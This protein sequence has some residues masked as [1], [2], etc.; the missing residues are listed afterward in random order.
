MEEQVNKFDRPEL[1]IEG[2]SAGY[3]RRTVLCDLSLSVMRGELLAVIGANGAGKSTLLKAIMGFADVTAGVISCSGRDITRIPP[4]RRVQL[5]LS[6]LMQ[7]AVVFQSLTVHENLSVAAAALP[8]QSRSAAVEQV[9]TDSPQINSLLRTR[10]GLLSGGQ[11]QALAIGMMMVRRPRVLLLDEP[12]AG[13]APR[14]ATETLKRL[15]EIGQATGVTVI[16]VEQRVR[17][18]LEIAT[19]AI[20]LNNGGVYAETRHPSDWLD[21]ERIE[22]H[23]FGPGLPG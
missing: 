19:R 6:C 14:V 2:L 7:G 4:H 12:S 18:V 21:L 10:A 20:I 8:R 15:V 23:I 3:G 13:L 9:L 17:Q 22:Q 16:V 1:L 11:R 5:G